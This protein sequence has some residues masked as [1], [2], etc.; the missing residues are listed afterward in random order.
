[1]DRKNSAGLSPF[2]AQVFPEDVVTAELRGTGDPLLL[3]P[4]EA[5][6]LGPVSPK[7]LQEFAAGRVCAHRALA[8]FGFGD[9]PLWMNDDRRP[10][11]PDA[12]V[13][14]ISHTTGIC[15]VAVARK[16]Q[17]RAIGLD[18]EIIG[19]VTS[20]I[21]P[22]MCTPEEIRWLA[23]MPSAEQS[24]YAALTFSAKESFYKCQYELTGQWL[25]FEDVMLEAVVI[26]GTDAGC[27]V[28]RP[29][30]MI[31]LLD[32]S[33]PLPLLGHFVFH[34]NLVITGMALK[35]V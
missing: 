35:A 33:P 30:R 6:S 28:L 34:A 21:W 29:R 15:G 31:A 8:E 24:R 18:M 23:G 19:R 20:E 16:K 12:V 10:C 13:G 11:W 32:H 22:A 4:G 9:H 27:Y 1:M 17:F 3:F 2:L 14:S 25:E 7:R 26:T 5:Q